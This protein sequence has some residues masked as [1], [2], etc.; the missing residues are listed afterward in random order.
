MNL[1]TMARLRLEVVV[2]RDG[3]S[4]RSPRYE[5]GKLLLAELGRGE[6]E[7]RHRLLPEPNTVRGFAQLPVGVPARGSFDTELF[8][9]F[10]DV[11]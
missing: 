9:I 10:L 4:D 8:L 5:S 7:T 6:E 11:F 2:H 1:P 3:S